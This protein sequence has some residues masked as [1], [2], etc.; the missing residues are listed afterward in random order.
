ME[1]EVGAPPCTQR[2]RSTALATALRELVTRRP[3]VEG[4]AAGSAEAAAPGI[5]GVIGGG[6]V[7]RDRCVPG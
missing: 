1:V 7:N 3:A 5:K 6:G 2:A 4:V